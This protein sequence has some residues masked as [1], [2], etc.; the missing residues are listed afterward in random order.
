[1]HAVSC[2]RVD[3]L[4]GEIPPVQHGN[5]HLSQTRIAW[6]NWQDA[7]TLPLSNERLRLLTA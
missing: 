5:V 4:I 1:M 6:S 3:H 7:P 2:E